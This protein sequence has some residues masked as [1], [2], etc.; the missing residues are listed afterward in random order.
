MSRSVLILSV[1]AG[2]IITVLAMAAVAF[3]D[4]DEGGPGEHKVTLCHEGHTITV[5]APAMAA[6]VRHGDTEGACGTEA[7]E[8]PGFVTL[9]DTTMPDATLPGTTTPDITVPDTTAP[10]A[11]TPGTTVPNTTVP[12][13]TMPDTTTPDATVPGTTTADRVVAISCGQDL[14][15]IVNADDPTIAT[16]FQLAGGCTYPVD[17]TVLLDEGD[18]IAGPQ[19]MFIVRGPAFDPEPTV[20]ISGSPGVANVIRAQGTVHLEWVTIVGGTGQYSGGSPEAGTGSGLAMGQAS[21]ASSLYAVHITGTDAA[22]ITNAHGTFDR[23]E[24]DDTTRDPNF[25]GFTGSGLKAITEVEV[26][27]SY[28]HDNQG[29]GIWCDQYCHDSASRANGFW[30]HDNLVVDNGRAGIRY[31]NVGDVADAGEALIENNDVHGNSFGEVRGGVSIHDAQNALVR[32]NVFGATT[33]A[34]VAY[35][36]DAGGVAIR[37]TDSGRSDRPDL[38]NADFVYN[39]LNG[40]VI[41]G[42]ESPSETVYCF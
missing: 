36:P 24:L 10:D 14:D 35:P 2:M 32:G 6:H 34:G 33:I 40:E 19:G 15:A 20:T 7:P 16:R 31:E 11:T 37:A 28:V 23:I 27:N 39:I 8:T 13:T 17:T 4:D 30:V 25:L 5:G 42:C 18:E 41:M 26:R 9:P 38:W 29:N 21:D 22:G 12:D 1:V 3:A